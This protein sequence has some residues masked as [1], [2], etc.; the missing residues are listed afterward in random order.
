MKWTKTRM[1]NV[2]K[3]QATRVAS[4]CNETKDKAKNPP[5]KGKVHDH[6]T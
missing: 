1:M 2:R 3:P 6:V 4:R 5:N